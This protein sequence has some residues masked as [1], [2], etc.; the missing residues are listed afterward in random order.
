[1]NLDILS[2]KKE[3]NINYLM[4]GRIMLRARL[5]NLLRHLKIIIKKR[6]IIE[7][8]ERENKFVIMN[9]FLLRFKYK[10]SNRKYIYIII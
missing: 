8:C 9:N 10:L 5:K 6:K 2:I 4:I 7:L 1:M 3:I